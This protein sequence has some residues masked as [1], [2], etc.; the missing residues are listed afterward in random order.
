MLFF[1]SAYDSPNQFEKLSLVAKIVTNENSGEKKESNMLPQGFLISAIFYL[2]I[3][4]ND[5]SASISFESKS[6]Q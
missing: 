3:Y 2:D 4:L 6:S 5:R 1:Y